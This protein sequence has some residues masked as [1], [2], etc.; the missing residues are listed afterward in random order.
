[1]SRGSLRLRR[2]PS[3]RGWFFHSCSISLARVSRKSVFPTP[4]PPLIAIMRSS[5]L[6][7]SINCRRIGMNECSTRKSWIRK[8][9]SSTGFCGSSITC[10]CPFCSIFSSFNTSFFSISAKILKICCKITKKNPYLQGLPYIFYKKNE[11]PRLW[12]L[13]NCHFILKKCTF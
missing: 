12:S 8:K 6:I 2:R 9:A 1:M 5:Q 7:S 3:G 11:R 10:G 13:K 4:R